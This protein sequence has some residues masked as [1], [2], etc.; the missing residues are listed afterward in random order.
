MDLRIG[1]GGCD[2]QPIS[3]RLDFSALRNWLEDCEM[4]HI[5]CSASRAVVE[6]RAVSHAGSSFRLIDTSKLVIVEVPTL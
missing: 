4:N 2:H 5:T 3:S 1:L 6:P